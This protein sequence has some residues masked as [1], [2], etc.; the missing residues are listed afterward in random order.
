MRLLTRTSATYFLNNKGEINMAN[1]NKKISETN[2]RLGEIR[3]SYANVFAPRK[4]EDGTPGKYSVMLVIPKSNTQAIELIKSA[5]EAA[6]AA[7]IAAKWNGKLPP[8]SKLKLPLRDGDEEFPEDDNFKDTVFLNASTTTAP[9]VRVLENGVMSE[10]L[11][12]DDF[13]SG[14]YGCATVNFYAY[15]ASGNVGVAAGLNNV[16]KT[17]DGE[18]LSGSHSAEDDFGDMVEKAGSYLD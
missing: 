15:S 17:R 13:Y 2:V 6:K 14:C 12:G 8:A 4:N 16:I 5:V 7:G 10:A 18:K 9:G 3:F 1:F 11:D